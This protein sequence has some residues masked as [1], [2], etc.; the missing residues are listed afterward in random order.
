MWF[1]NGKPAAPQERVRSGFHV[2]SLDRPCL[3]LLFVGVRRCPTVCKNITNDRRLS[4]ELHAFLHIVKGCQLPAVWFP[5]PSTKNACASV[6]WVHL[7]AWF[8]TARAP[9]EIIRVGFQAIPASIRES[10]M[11]PSTVSVVPS[12]HGTNS[13]C[14]LAITLGDGSYVV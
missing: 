11:T 2:I 12:A 7:R 13:I 5:A 14:S 1:G 10:G 3:R 9:R 8:L 4:T 6:H